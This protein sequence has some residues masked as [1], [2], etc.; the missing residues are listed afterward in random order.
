[1][2]YRKIEILRQRIREITGRD[3]SR[4]IQVFEDTT[5]FMAIDAGH[6]LRLNGNDYIITGHAR[7]GRFG[8]D[9]QPKFWVKNCIDLTTGTRK[10]IKL[11]FQETFDNKVGETVY[12]FSRSG[13]KEAAVL[14]AMR[15]HPHFMQGSSVRDTAGNMVRILD[16][17]A[18]SSL[19]DHLRRLPMSH[20]QY[21]DTEFFPI[22]KNF[23]ACV[24][25]IAELHEKGLHHGDI[26]ADHIIINHQ[27]R[28]YVWIDF[29]YAVDI[30]EYDTLCLGN[31]LLQVAGKGRHTIHNIQDNPE[32]YPDFGGT[33][34]I[35]DM[36]LMFKY[37]VA[38]LQRLFPHIPD[39]LNKILLRYC[40]GGADPYKTAV[41]LLAD[42]S[43]I[44]GQP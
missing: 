26:R 1:M 31:V 30:P 8:I 27:T 39:N 6:I 5:E 37:R 13:E 20:R 33:L 28:Q 23:M 24:R 35:E 42:L 29:D 34:Y 11:V 16:F 25:A 19:Y 38:N 17:I 32:A 40:V 3:P 43:E 41:G 15:N 22:M 7:E 2:I 14:A 10:V 4:R 44:F 36:S 18:G 9:D 21:M 12:R